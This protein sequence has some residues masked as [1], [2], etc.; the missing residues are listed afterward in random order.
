[1][2]VLFLAAEA[3][4]ADTGNGSKNFHVPPSVPNYFSNEAGPLQGPSSETRRGDLYANHGSAE[5]PRATA[6]VAPTPRA[7]QHVAMAAPR[8]PAIRG[9]RGERVVARHVAVHGRSATRVAAHGSS[10]THLA[11]R[12]AAHGSS[13]THSA[14]VAARPHG[15]AKTTRVVSSHRHARG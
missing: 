14:H 2:T 1:M 9:R 11:T 6:A 4:A 7:R 12:V 3:R 13:R 15:A 5:P 10:R 8:G